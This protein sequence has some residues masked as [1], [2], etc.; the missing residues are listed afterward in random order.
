M[1]LRCDAQVCFA[2]GQLILLQTFEDD[3]AGLSQLRWRRALRARMLSTRQLLLPRSSV[4][5][6]IWACSAVLCMVRACVAA[7][8][9]RSGSLVDVPGRL[10]ACDAL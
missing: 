10:S 2:S 8:G 1:L 6:R 7:L 4:L 3:L 5:S 9:S